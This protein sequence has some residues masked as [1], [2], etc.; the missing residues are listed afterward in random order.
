VDVLCVDY[1]SHIKFHVVTKYFSNLSHYFPYL[2]ENYINLASCHSSSGQTH[3][4]SN[5]C[6]V[7]WLSDSSNCYMWL[8]R[9]ILSCLL[10][11][12]EVV[13]IPKSYKVYVFCVHYSTHQTVTCG[14]EVVFSLIPLFSLFF[15]ELYILVSL[16]QYK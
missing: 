1:P 10:A 13:D 15:R 16:P 12:V 14:Y 8:H 11:T 4:L 7:L 5:G 3:I 2:Q 6:I 9:T